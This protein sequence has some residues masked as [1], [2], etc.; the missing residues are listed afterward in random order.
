M[1]LTRETERGGPCRPIETEVNRDSGSTYGRVSFLGYVP[2]PWS[3]P[4]IEG[5]I[6]YS[7][8]KKNT[9]KVHKNENFFGSDFEICSISLLVMLKY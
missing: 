9:L 4:K 1:A 6:T 2:H 5:V 8:G 3:L 7:S